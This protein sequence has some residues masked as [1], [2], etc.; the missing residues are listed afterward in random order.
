MTEATQQQQQQQQQLIKHSLYA[1][2]LLDTFTHKTSFNPVSL[3]LLL[4]PFDK[5]EK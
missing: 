2:T 5:G 1:N 4:F 3:E